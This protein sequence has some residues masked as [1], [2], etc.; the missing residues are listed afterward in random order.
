MAQGPY[1][2]TG[3]SKGIGRAI[4]QKLAA[5]GHPVLALARASKEL[6]EIGEELADICS[7]SRAIE[8]DLSQPESIKHAAQLILQ[9]APWIAGIVH[10]LGLFFQSCHLL[11]L[12]LH[13]GQRQSMPI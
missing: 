9:S 5:D 4:S 2:V 13:T 11:R 6:D 10:M 12:K 8:C 7:G 3:A 1:V